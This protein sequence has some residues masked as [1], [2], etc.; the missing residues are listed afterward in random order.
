MRVLDERLT[1]E[2]P[3]QRMR[4]HSWRTMVEAEVLPRV[5]GL[6]LARGLLHVRDPEW[7]VCGA[8]E[9]RSLFSRAFTVQLLVMPLYVPADHVAWLVGERLGRLTSDRD[10]WWDPGVEAGETIGADVAA[11][12][13]DGALD[14]WAR[15]GTPH[16][17]TAEC[18]RRATFAI[19]AH[20]LELV[21][22]AAII[23]GDDDVAADAFALARRLHP[24]RPRELSVQ[25]RIAELEAAS[26]SDREVALALL[27]QARDRTASALGLA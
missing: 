10:I 2:H 19:D 20:Q 24:T 16:A 7:L 23:T 1:R 12:L 3:V 14:Y 27:R 17:L 26:A 18:R 4:K 22:G 9:I 11:R 25:A 21:A 6:A 13:H 5:P 8:V 15:L